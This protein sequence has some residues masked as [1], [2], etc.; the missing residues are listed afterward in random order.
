[1]WQSIWQSVEYFK[2]YQSDVAALHSTPF[3]FTLLIFAKHGH[4]QLLKTQ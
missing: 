4:K 1:M 3:L 2:V